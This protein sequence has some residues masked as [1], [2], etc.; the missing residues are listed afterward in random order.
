MKALNLKQKNDF[1]YYK[2][3][4]VRRIA[5]AYYD[6]SSLGMFALNAPYA[7]YYG[8]TVDEKRRCDRGGFGSSIDNLLKWYDYVIDLKT[9][10]TWHVEE[11]VSHTQ[12][13][14]EDNGFVQ[15]IFFHEGSWFECS[16]S[17]DWFSDNY[18]MKQSARKI[19]GTDRHLCFIERMKNEKDN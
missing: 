1:T 18:C 12:V 16:G 4:K 15:V 7:K 14:D 10:E 13:Y 11:V 2:F 5:G 17:P 8:C 9:G 3:K 6:T 19:K